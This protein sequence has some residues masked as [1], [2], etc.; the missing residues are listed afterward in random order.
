MSK[1]KKEPEVKLIPKSKNKTIF[2][3]IVLLVVCAGAAVLFFKKKPVEI[4]EIVDVVV[5]K[6]SLVSDEIP[7]DS[8]ILKDSIIYVD[9]LEIESIEMLE[10]S[11]KRVTKKNSK[12][13]MDNN[14]KYWVVFKGSDKDTTFYT[15]K[16]K[17]T[18][19][20]L[21]NKYFTKEKADKELNNFKNIISN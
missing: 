20:K 8:I 9:T 19:T 3:L 4:N 12:V 7:S 13:K 15:L 1:E 17:K 16:N 6:D 18:G 10:P 11:K 14:P 21:S 5:V 2:I